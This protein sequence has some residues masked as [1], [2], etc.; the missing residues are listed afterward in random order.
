MI[1]LIHRFKLTVKDQLFY[2]QF[3]Y[4]IGFQL[5]EVSC[6]RELDHSYIDTMIERRRAWREVAH[7]RWQ[8]SNNTF[9]NI[10][11]R[12]TREITDKTVSDLHELADQLLNS[13][14][15]F[16][17]V[18]S[19]NH[20]HVYSNDLQLIDQVGDLK[21]L[22]QKTYS[23]AI[24]GRPKNTIRLKDPKYRF[25]SYFKSTKITE[26]QKNH[27]LAFLTTQT[28]IRISPALSGWVLTPFHRTQDYFFVDHNEMSWLTMLSLVRPGLI[29]KTMQ[30][31]PT[32]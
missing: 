5:D 16:K 28:E 15:D 29:R 26:E 11:T 13:Q 1:K 21:S 6:L 4:V 20:A 19:A 27:L 2:N 9:G 17:L 18:V 31:I 32:K 10:L 8:K 22:K 25:R 7:Q 12:R 3:E 30:I 14:S 23:R 24:V